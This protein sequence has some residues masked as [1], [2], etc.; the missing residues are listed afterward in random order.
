M[1][2]WLA[3][4][5]IAA[6]GCRIGFDS[7]QDAPALTTPP[8]S[9][10]RVGTLTTTLADFTLPVVL[11]DARADRTAMAADGSDLR[12][13]DLDGTLL[14]HEIAQLGTP[15]GP[16]LIAWVRVP[17]LSATSAIQV[18]YGRAITPP[19]STSSPW[20]SDVAAVYHFEEPT[21]SPRD[22]TT[23]HLDTVA[24]GT[25]TV[26]G[27]CGA[28]RRFVAASRDVLV[29][30]DAPSLALPTFT[31]SGWF[32][33]NALPP[34]G[35]YQALVTREYAATGLNDFWLGDRTGLHYAALDTTTDGSLNFTAT[36]ATARTWVHLALTADGAVARLY[37]NG[38][39]R[40]A[41]PI[42]GPVVH[43]PRPI[44]LGADASFGAGPD[45]DFL[46]GFIDE[47]KIETVARDPA[48]I[49]AD[50]LAMRDL[51]IEYGP[52][53]P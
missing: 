21:G 16:P 49:Q 13:Y 40:A 19:V 11:D 52:V 45:A 34:P 14:A 38:V 2:I 33:E 43:S 3:A 8:R 17:S 30:A 35:I 26:A 46:D 28:G 37:V 23:A 51:L 1:W 4:C 25:T 53:D 39:E 36:A 32:Y 22:A 41:R 7:D 10:L 50:Y 9:T 27:Q 47:V 31:V 24:T 20:R 6:M 18:E 29:I 15:G 48:W 12:F 5:A 42:T 44:L